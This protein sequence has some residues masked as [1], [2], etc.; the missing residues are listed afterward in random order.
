MRPICITYTFNKDYCQQDY[1]NCTGTIPVFRTGNVKYIIIRF[2]SFP[3]T[4]IY[5]VKSFAL[6]ESTCYFVFFSFCW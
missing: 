4:K 6:T 1:W 2:V 5:G 3:G